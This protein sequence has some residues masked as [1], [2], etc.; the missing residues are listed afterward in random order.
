MEAVRPLETS[1]PR[2]YG[3]RGAALDADRESGRDLD[4][5]DARE[6]IVSRLRLAGASGHGVIQVTAIV[7]TGHVKSSWP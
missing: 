4:D 7:E 5:A 2:K 3:A 1:V 6:M